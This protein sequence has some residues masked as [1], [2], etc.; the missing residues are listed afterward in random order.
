MHVE[1]ISRTRDYF[2]K[3]GFRPYQWTINVDTPLAPLTKP[4]EESRVA[5]L[6]SGGIYLQSQEPF[7]PERDDLTFHEIPIDTPQQSLR[8][9]HANYNHAGAEQDINCVLPIHRLPELVSEGLIGSV[10]QNAITFMGRIFKRTELINEM[11][12]KMLQRL[13]EMGADIALL[14]P[15]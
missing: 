11:M 7:N 1:Y 10:A 5:L 15:V 4:L 14:V 8:I 13:R 6:G 9:S 12:P 3:K 2:V